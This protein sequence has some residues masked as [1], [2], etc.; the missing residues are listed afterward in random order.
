[1]HCKCRVAD[2]DFQITSF[3]NLTHSITIWSTFHQTFVR[4]FLNWLFL[5]CSLFVCFYLI[6]ILLIQHIN[7]QI[8]YICIIKVRIL[9]YSCTRKCE[10][11]KSYNKIKTI[12][13]HGFEHNSLSLSDQTN[14]WGTYSQTSMQNTSGFNV[15]SKPRFPYQY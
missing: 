13:F 1:M 6:F 11:H 15:N 7:L 12:N 14:V 8:T 4:T 3:T 5:S 2:E 10:Q 9:F